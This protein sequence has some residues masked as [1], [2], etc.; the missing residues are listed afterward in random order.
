MSPV[1]SN[2]VIPITL[3]TD[4][5]FIRSCEQNS[6]IPREPLDSGVSVDTDYY[7]SLEC[8]GR[9]YR[10]V[11]AFVL[12][13]NGTCEHEGGNT[14][15]Q[16]SCETTSKPQRT[17]TAVASTC[18]NGTTACTCTSSDFPIYSCQV[19]N[20]VSY[21]HTMAGCEP[22]RAQVSP[23]EG[24]LVVATG[25]SCA[26]ADATTLEVIRT[27]VCLPYADNGDFATV[28]Y[29][30]DGDSYTTHAFYDQNCSEAPYSETSLFVD[31]ANCDSGP[32]ATNYTCYVNTSSYTPPTGFALDSTLYYTDECVVSDFIYSQTY[33]KPYVA[34]LAECAAHAA[35]VAAAGDDGLP[36]YT[37][38]TGDAADSGSYSLSLCTNDCD[39]CEAQETYTAGECVERTPASRL[40]VAPL[41]ACQPPS[42]APTAE[43][44]PAPTAGNGTTT[45]GNGTT[46]TPSPTP[47]PPSN[48]TT[49]NG[50]TP[51]PTTESKGSSAVNGAQRVS[52]SAST[53]AAI[54][55][56]FAA[57]ALLMLTTI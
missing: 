30:C 18:T 43:P 39:N 41:G 45:T 7:P 34:T 29:E 46:T 10:H 24:R 36:L 5:N 48:E 50:T 42:P 16:L 25:S 56:A 1:S 21:E 32:P 6:T 40:L 8:F 3:G 17:A 35:D 57:C 44:T 27:G 49:G 47:A 15:A 4:G 13:A 51:A 33:R 23:F 31:I 28:K 12:D 55:T 11:K 9:V 52:A 54:V 53:A 26:P 2:P 19:S 22:P 37:C 38:A 20:G 14:Y